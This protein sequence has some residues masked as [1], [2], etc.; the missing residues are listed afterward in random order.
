MTDLQEL[1]GLTA[2]DVMHSNLSTLP[3]SATV[4]EVRDYLGGSSSRRLVLLVDGDRFAGSIPAASLPVDAD[5]S[6]PASAYV[7][8]EPTIG[9]QAAAAEARDLALS[10]ATRRVPVVDDSGALVGIVAID[11][12]H[13]RFCGA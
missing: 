8:P 7:A 6:A 3:A 10:L 1:D 11:E 13:T 2:A 5:A 12:N 9:P 4:A